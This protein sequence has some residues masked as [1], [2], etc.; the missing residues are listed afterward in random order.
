MQRDVVYKTNA[1]FQ[2]AILGELLKKYIFIADLF[3]FFMRKNGL[4]G[5]DLLSNYKRG[6]NSL[7]SKKSVV[8]IYDTCRCSLPQ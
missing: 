8:I 7:Y 3:L 2:K 6:V 1:I 4:L 5:I